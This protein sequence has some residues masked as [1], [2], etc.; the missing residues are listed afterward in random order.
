MTFMLQGHALSRN[1]NS[2]TNELWGCL[3]AASGQP[4]A[5][6]LSHKKKALFFGAKSLKKWTNIEDAHGFPQFHGEGTCYIML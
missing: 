1:S 5:E 2:T 6:H 3:A 4:V